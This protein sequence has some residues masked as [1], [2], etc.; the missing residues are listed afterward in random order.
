MDLARRDVLRS[1]IAAGVGFTGAAALAT[2]QGLTGDALARSAANQELGWGPVRPK[3]A[4][5]TGVQWLALP[6]GF[7]YNAFGQTGDAMADGRKTPPAHDGMACFLVRGELRLVRNH[8]ARDEAA[9]GASIGP[10]EKSYDATAAGGTTT[11]VVDPET[12]LLKRDWVSLSGTHVNCAGGPSPWGSWL[13]CEETVAGNVQAKVHHKEPDA[14]VGGYEREHGYVFE[15]PAW[16]DEPADPQPIRGMGRF[17]HEALAF[18]PS[19]GICYLT[20]DTGEAGFYRFI[21]NVPGRM[22]EG[23][24]LQMAVI[25]GKPQHDTRQGQPQGASHQIAWVDIQDP[26]PADAGINEKAVFS[27]GLAQGGAIFGRLEGAWYGEGSIYINSTSGGDARQGQVWRYRPTGEGGILTLIYESQA[28]EVLKAPDN[29]CVS[30]R[31]ALVVCEDGSGMNRIHGLTID[32]RLFDIAHNVFNGSEFAGSCFSPDGR[33]L[34]V[35]I[36]NPGVTLAI[37]G[38]FEKGGL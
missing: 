30:P 19:T 4:Q 11:L 5:N 9:P 15:V 7:E 8:E 37:W 17:V 31:G 33:T 22:L 13:S 10:V 25:V 24:R 29:I 2:R 18:D 38:P 26:D 16:I 32:G 14:I 35:N 6:E 21:P 27:Q 36:Q 34:F 1:A 12:R 28:A 20:E 23:G 3:A